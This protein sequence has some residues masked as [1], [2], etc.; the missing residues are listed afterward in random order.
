MQIRINKKYIPVFATLFVFLTLYFIGSAAFRGFFS[1]RVFLNLFYDNAFIG[2]IA[3]GMTFVIIS[4]GIDLSVGSVV[5]FT[6]MFIAYMVEVV[7]MDPMLT[8]L[9]SIL[10]GAVAGFVM[11]CLIHFP[12]LPPF[13]VTLVGMFFFRGMAYQVSLGSIPLKHEFF[14]NL[15]VLRVPLIPGLVNVPIVTVIFLIM[16]IIG[17]YLYRWNKY[18]RNVY[19]IGGNEQSA[20]LMG[21]PVGRTKLFVYIFSGMCSALGGV[22]YAIYTLSGYALAGVGLELDV[23]AAVVIGGTLLSGGSGF[24][25]GTLLGVLILGLIQ[26]IL[27]FYGQLSSWWLRI[28]IG[29]LLFIFILLQT[30]LSKTAKFRKKKLKDKIEEIN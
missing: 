17:I 21:L 27:N 24:I 12:E 14:T 26:T 4:G 6:C 10:I 7:H 9:L 8:I 22:L 20:V 30:Y 15:A 3:V 2:V 1:L 13:L 29:C 18:A 5:G 28:F 11:G 19:A 23:I 16:V 25:E